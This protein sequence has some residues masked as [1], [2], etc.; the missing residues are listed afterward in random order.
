[1]D[2][3]AQELECK[4]DT[5]LSAPH[6][7]D[8]EQIQAFTVARS[9]AGTALTSVHERLKNVGPQIYR[10]IGEILT[11]L[12]PLIPG[13]VLLFLPSKTVKNGM[14]S[15]WRQS[16]IWK[17]LAESKPIFSEGDK[18]CTFAKY[19]ESI[20]AGAGGLLLAVCRGSMS[21]GI[22]FSDAQ[23]RAVFAFG[24]PYPNLVEADVVLKREYTERHFGV[25]A[26]REW[27]DTQAY[28]SLFQAVG[29]CIRHARD[30]GA[31]FLLDE[32]FTNQM[33]R[34]PNWMRG[35]FTADAQ[36]EDIHARLEQFY[37][38]MAVKFPCSAPST[39]ASL[40]FAATFTLTCARC[41][42]T[43]LTGVKVS[44]VAT[45]FCATRGF[46]SAMQS[47]QGEFVLI[48]KTDERKAFHGLEGAS[49]WSDEES[50]AFRTLS[51]TCG[52]IIGCRIHSVSKMDLAALDDMRLGINR[53]YAAQGKQSV[54]L[55]AIVQ[56][57]KRLQLGGGEGGGQLT[58]KFA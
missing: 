43:L 8:S 38:E 35:R 23:A 50:V 46:L 28:R 57:P 21:E 11:T 20:R 17:R 4:F 25:Q 24:I 40:S 7:V 29:R 47:D 37:A 48:V 5:R 10:G 3:L 45:D 6:I 52:A 32:R 1:M 14:V 30:Y 26:A 44:P 9:P 15:E 56:K 58:L 12:I 55:D 27:Y 42:K 34:F 16:G 49:L 2:S 51:C 33:K 22:D 19:S 18:G 41:T 13:G 54:P 39:Q 31:I 36:I 53:L